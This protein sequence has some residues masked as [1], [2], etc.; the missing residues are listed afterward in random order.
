ML[1][2]APQMVKSILESL[3]KVRNGP[4]G[5]FESLDGE[6]SNLSMVNQCDVDK[7]PGGQTMAYPPARDSCPTVALEQPNPRRGIRRTPVGGKATGGP[8][9]EGALLL[10]FVKRKTPA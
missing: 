9:H 7:R 3:A 5:E 10:P 2:V 8:R 1:K 6:S 4:N